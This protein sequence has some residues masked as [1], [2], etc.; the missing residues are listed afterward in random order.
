MGRAKPKPKPERKPEP[1]PAA[2]ANGQAGEVL[3]LAEAAAY[4]RLSEKDV[5]AA[6]TTQGLPARQMV[7]GEWRFFKGAIQQ[8]LSVS[9]PTADMRKAAL[10]AAAGSLKD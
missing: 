1:A 3:S 5:M 2:P 10:L 6:V 7:S 9:Q 8:W 4:L